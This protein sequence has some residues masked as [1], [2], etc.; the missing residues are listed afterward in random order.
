[1][2]LILSRVIA[3]TVP[4]ASLLATRIWG[5]DLGRVRS[6]SDSWVWLVP[7]AVVHRS[8]RNG[9]NAEDKF[10]ILDVTTTGNLTLTPSQIPTFPS[11]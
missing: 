2:G 9:T 3:K 6:L 1:M 11:T 8:V 5:V 7:T 4:I 10:H